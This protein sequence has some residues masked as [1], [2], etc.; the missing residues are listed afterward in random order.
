M[1]EKSI[2]KASELINCQR[3]HEIKLR[4]QPCAHDRHRIWPIPARQHEENH[5]D[6]DAAVRSKKTDEPP[7]W[8]P[9][10]QVRRKDGL[11][12]AANSPEISNLEPALVSAPHR[13]DHHDDAPIAH[14]HWQ[15]L[16]PIHDALTPDKDQIS[17][18]V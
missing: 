2:V 7:V 10:A 6:N 13:N 9:I 18:I 14:L 1:Q 11:Q 3:D 17:K 15:H 12:R 5:A 8:K 16:P 4:P